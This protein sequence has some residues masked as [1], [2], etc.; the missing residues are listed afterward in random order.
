MQIWGGEMQIWVGQRHV[1]DERRVVGL[2]VD[3]VGVRARVRV[4]VRARVRVRVRVKGLVVDVTGRR[5]G[6]GGDAVGR[7]PVALV[8]VA[9]DMQRRPHPARDRIQQLEA[10]CTRGSLRACHPGKDHRGP[11]T[12]YYLLLT[13]YALLLV[14]YALATLA[15]IAVA[16]RR[17]VRD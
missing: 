5:V 10:A 14:T 9:E 13:T 16:E 7:G 17:A 15:Q 3:L 12:T 2:V 1:E 8:N 11:H 6:E 4:R